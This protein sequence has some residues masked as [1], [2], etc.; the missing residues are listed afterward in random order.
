MTP[1]LPGPAVVPVAE[2]D[3]LRAE[4]VGERQQREGLERELAEVRI[5]LARA[6]TRAE[7]AEVLRAERDRLLAKVVDLRRSWIVRVVGQVRAALRR[8]P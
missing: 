7:V 4:L 2:L 6:E 1:G 8:Q 3:A 5:A